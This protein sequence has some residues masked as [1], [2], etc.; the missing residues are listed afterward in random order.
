MSENQNPLKPTEVRQ[1]CFDNGLI[2][3]DLQWQ[4]LE[5]WADLL[6]N[7][8]QEINLISRKET[9][10]L[11]EKQILHCLSLLV[12]KEIPQGVEAVS[13]THL[14]LPTKRIV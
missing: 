4:L 7:Y 6:L 13:Y 9:D 5:E 3:T 1:I 10:L 14:T 12:Y 11:W 8:N 2:I